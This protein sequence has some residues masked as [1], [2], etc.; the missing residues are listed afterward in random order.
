[1][2][3]E[4]ESDLEKRAVWETVLE[5]NRL[6][7]R[8]NRPE[9]LADFFHEKMLAVCGGESIIRPDGRACLDGWTWFCREAQDL[10]F[11]ERDPHI[12]MFCDGT[13]AVVAYFFDCSYKL[14]GKAAVMKGRDLFTLI[15]ENGRWRVAGD[16]FSPI[17]PT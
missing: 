11:E 3:N 7:S 14:N 9:A 6:W 13:V 5:I 4:F 15:K 10:C 2:T 1:M 17:V 8:D 16:H 12:A